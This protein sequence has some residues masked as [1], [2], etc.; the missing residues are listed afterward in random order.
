MPPPMFCTTIG[1]LPT[2]APAGLCVKNDKS[3]V[4]AP[5]GF[6]GSLLKREFLGSSRTANRR[7]PCCN[8]NRIL[9]QRYRRR[10][11]AAANRRGQR[12]RRQNV[13]H[14]SPR[15][16]RMCREIRYSAVL[17]GYLNT[18][19]QSCDCAPIICFCA[20][21]ICN[22]EAERAGCAWDRCDHSIEVKKPFHRL[23]LKLVHPD[24]RLS[25]RFSF[26]NIANQRSSLVCALRRETRV[27][28]IQPPAPAPRAGISSG[29]KAP[30][31]VEPHDW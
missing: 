27:G 3:I 26:H 20:P 17:M 11:S 29:R 22:V 5:Y 23:L 31:D 28:S 24:C 2:V 16:A 8:L 18:C 6:N 21:H 19:A 30:R 4:S 1:V 10:P 14:S 13:S 9:C 12:A 7:C 15:A 25:E